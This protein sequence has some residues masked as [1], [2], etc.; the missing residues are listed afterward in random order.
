MTG[1]TCDHRPPRRRPTSIRRPKLAARAAIQVSLRWK[2]SFAQELILALSVRARSYEDAEGT[3]T[4]SSVADDS[5]GANAAAAL[6]RHLA[7]TRGA[8]EKA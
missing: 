3:A 8:A 1:S 5:L 4:A 2:L 6:T 7:P